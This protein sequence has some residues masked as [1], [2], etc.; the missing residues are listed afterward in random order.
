MGKL[1]A[2]IP[3]EDPERCGPKHSPRPEQH[4]GCCTA[5]QPMECRANHVMQLTMRDGCCCVHR[6]VHGRRIKRVLDAKWRTIG[7]SARRLTVQ[8]D[9]RA[10]C[11]ALLALL[12]LLPWRAARP[13]LTGRTRR[14]QI[15]TEALAQQVSDKKERDRLERERD[16]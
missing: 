1:V 2:Q 16:E 15:D 11:A 14:A 4:A 13:F 10:R 12:L 5:L 3:N 8:R 9:L 6:A 7:V